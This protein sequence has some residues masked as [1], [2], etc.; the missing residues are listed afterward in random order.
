MLSRAWK[1][2]K[3]IRNSHS[4]QSSQGRVEKKNNRLLWFVLSLLLVCVPFVQGTSFGVCS[5]SAACMSKLSFNYINALATLREVLLDFIA[6]TLAAHQTSWSEMAR[7]LYQLW[8]SEHFTYNPCGEIQLLNTLVF[9]GIGGNRA[10]WKVWAIFMQLALS[11]EKEPL[12]SYVWRQPFY[13]FYRQ[14]Q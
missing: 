3:W 4:H 13:N 10:L 2:T 6:N 1:G 5:R 8:L 12:Q 14:S 7:V 9:L 11:I